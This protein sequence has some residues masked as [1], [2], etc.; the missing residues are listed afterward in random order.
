VRPRKSHLLSALRL[1]SLGHVLFLVDRVRVVAPLHEL[2]LQNSLA[3]STHSKTQLVPGV[4]KVIRTS[5]AS[6]K[7]CG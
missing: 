6:E 7:K 3:C 1:L 2:G 5:E 4:E